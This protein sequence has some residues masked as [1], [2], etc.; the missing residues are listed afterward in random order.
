MEQ[1]TETLRKLIF[2]LLKKS[3]V[4]LGHELKKVNAGITPMQY[5]ILIHLDKK[6]FTLNELSHHLANKPPT[7]IPAIDYLEQSGYIKRE[8]DTEDRRK[9]NLIITAKGKEVLKKVPSG[10]LSDFL[11]KGIKKLGKERTETLIS[12]LKELSD[13]VDDERQM[14]DSC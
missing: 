10:H 9:V 3:H 4:H 12:L 11:H 1:Q 6:E 2:C 13:A 8:Q 14:K 7:L 5:A